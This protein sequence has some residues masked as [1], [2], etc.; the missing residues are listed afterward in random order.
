[1]VGWIL[2]HLKHRH[3]S[4]LSTQWSHPFTYSYV[5]KL[6]QFWKNLNRKEFVITV[7]LWCACDLPELFSLQ[8]NSNITSNFKTFT[9]SKNREETPTKIPPNKTCENLHPPQGFPT[10]LLLFRLK[11]KL[12]G[13]K[14]RPQHCEGGGG[15][16]LKNPDFC[17]Q[18]S[19]QFAQSRIS[20]K[21]CVGFWIFT[22]QFFP[23][24]GE[25]HLANNKK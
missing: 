8:E 11:K 2:N 3:V 1:M 17:V 24:R 21:V 5:S 15:R 14:D 6:W 18:N 12:R 25:N 19:H 22:W 4:L 23:L 20:S 9:T 13:P 10:H 7:W 16:H